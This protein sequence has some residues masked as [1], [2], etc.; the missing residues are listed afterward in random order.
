M[1][2]YNPNPA[3]YDI[4]QTVA[5]ANGATADMGEPETTAALPAITYSVPS[6]QLE[7][8]HDEQSRIGKQ[9]IDITVDVWADSGDTA[10]TLVNA[11]VTAFHNAGYM[12][13]S[14]NDVPDP[15]DRRV[16]HKTMTIKLIK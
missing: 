14:T 11:L 1:D 15:S 3:V 10:S 9:D 8:T 5:T 7:H 12:V 16:V 6:N 4:I 2:Y 13:T